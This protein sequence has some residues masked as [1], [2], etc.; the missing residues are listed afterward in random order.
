MNNMIY[1]SRDKKNSKKIDEFIKEFGLMA[2]YQSKHETV[3][4]CE[5][6]IMSLRKKYIMLNILS[7]RS[8]VVQD[9]Q[10][11]FRLEMDI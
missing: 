11:F 7:P 3:L 6:V 9:V 4:K 2:C 8:N 10:N 1:I 5:D